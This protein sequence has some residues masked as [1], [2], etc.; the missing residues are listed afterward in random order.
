M[1]NGCSERASSRIAGHARVRPSRLLARFFLDYIARQSV[2]LPGQV[3][4][5]G[6][7]LL[8]R[9]GLGPFAELRSQL[10]VVRQAFRVGHTS[11]RRSQVV[12]RESAWRYID[13]A[14][15]NSESTATGNATAR[16]TI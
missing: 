11:A 10:A 15:L 14:R 1:I 7:S 12:H 13:C 4:Q 3:E 16:P 6:P 5:T 8:V 9:L 2:V